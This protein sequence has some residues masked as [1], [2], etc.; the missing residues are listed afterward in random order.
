MEAGTKF[1]RVAAIDEVPAGAM[2]SVA[3]DGVQ[4]L[5]CNVGGEYYAVHDECTHECFPLSEGTLEGHSLTCILHGACFDV[6]T[7]EVLALP[8][9]GPL[10]TYEVKVDGDDLLIATD[11]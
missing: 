6:R 9:Y 8:A 5:L 1:V 2:K 10:R 3:V 4:V 11:R 7:G